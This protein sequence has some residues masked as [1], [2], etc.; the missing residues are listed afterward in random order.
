M[1][2]AALYTAES[3]TLFGELWS[4]REAHMKSMKAEGEYRD[5]IKAKIIALEGNTSLLK[6]YS[7]M[8]QVPFLSRL[9][10]P[11]EADAAFSW[12]G[13]MNK[14]MLSISWCCRR[15]R[16][17]CS[18]RGGCW[19]IPTCSPSTCLATSSTGM[20][21]HRSRMPSTRTSLRTSSSSWN[22]RCALLLC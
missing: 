7:W 2:Y 8:S 1:L 20:R 21:S 11:P 13:C 3:L 15:R 9:L 19:A 17:S 6:D 4:C 14:T 5:R 16:S 18:M 10:Q 22:Q 12:E